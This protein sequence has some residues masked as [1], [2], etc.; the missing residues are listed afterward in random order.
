MSRDMTGWKYQSND[1][2]DWKYLG[3]DIDSALKNIAGM[4]SLVLQH[5]DPLPPIIKEQGLKPEDTIFAPFF[6]KK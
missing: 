4:G 3:Y 1:R 2:R 6:K 5:T